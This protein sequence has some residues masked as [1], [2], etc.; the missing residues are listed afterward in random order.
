MAVFEGEH[1]SPSSRTTAS[2]PRLRRHDAPRLRG[3][4]GHRPHPLLDA[5][6]GRLARAQPVY[7]S[8]GRAGFALAHNGN[9][10]N[11]EAARRASSA[12][13]GH[14]GS[15]TRT[16]SPSCSP[17]PTTTTWP[18]RPLREALC[19]VLPQRRGRVLADDPRRPPGLRACATPTASA[20]C[21]SA[22]SA[23]R[24][25]PRAGSSPRSRRRS[26]SIGATFVRE[27]EPGEMVTHQPRGRQSVQ[28]LRRR[29]ARQAE[30]VHLRVRLLRPA[31]HRSSWATRSTRRAGAWASCWPARRRSTPT[32]SWACPTRAC[33]AAEGFA[34]ASGIPFGYG[35]MKNRYIGRTFIAPTRTSA[36]QGRAAQAQPAA[37][38]HR[39]Q[40]PRRRRRL[41]RA[42]H[43]ARGRWC[44]CCATPAQPRCTCA[45]RRRRSCGPASTA[46]TPRRAT[47]CW[48]P[49]TR[50]PR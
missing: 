35:L 42:R 23:P 27:I 32:S 21:A 7:R 30:A 3:Q 47:S 31:R 17:A 5:G 24:T 13:A 19:E 39:G 41:D 20:R 11:T 6:L 10:T 49:T 1:R 4:P 36:R 15:R 26:T 48:R 43:D 14:A 34:K 44:G 40:A 18:G 16:S 38:E 45:S 12:A 22:A 33:P 37:R 28:L 29:R 2:S 8:A 25:R 50:S 9:L 46:S